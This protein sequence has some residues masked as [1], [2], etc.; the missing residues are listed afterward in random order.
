M[1]GIDG[2]PGHAMLRNWLGGLMGGNFP[3][4]GRQ[5]MGQ[6]VSGLM[7]PPN[8]GMQAVPSNFMNRPNYNAAATAKYGPYWA[9][10]LGPAP[11]GTAR[12]GYNAAATEKYGPLYAQLLGSK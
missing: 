5:R 1:L 11:Q 4:Q 7:Q 8:P 9:E 6:A 3:D 12:E 10:R 2:Q